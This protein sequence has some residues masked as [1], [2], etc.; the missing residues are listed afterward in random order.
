M[1]RLIGLLTLLCSVAAACGSSDSALTPDTPGPT[2]TSAVSDTTSTPP[3]PIVERVTDRSSAD[4]NAP[5]DAWV[6][7]VN[8]A[9][10]DFHRHLEGNAVSSPMSIGV[11]FS[12]SRAGAS[13]DSGAALDK[14]FGFPRD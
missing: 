10:W 3:A 5:N 1:T 6:A 12:L 9:G 14:I 8:G 7:G 2:A 11:A 13:P 4:T